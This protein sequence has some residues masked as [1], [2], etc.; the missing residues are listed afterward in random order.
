MSALSVHL[1][2]CHVQLG[3][4]WGKELNFPKPLA[5]PFHKHVSFSRSVQLVHSTFP[6]L[7]PLTTSTLAV[8]RRGSQHFESIYFYN[9]SYILF[10]FFILIFLACIL[11]VLF[12]YLWMSIGLHHLTPLLHDVQLPFF[13]YYMLYDN[14]NT[15]L[16]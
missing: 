15:L 11:C 6:S 1:G 2:N 14:L 12:I 7:S 8:L 10:L 3:D 4:C 13:S 16:V 5:P 9:S